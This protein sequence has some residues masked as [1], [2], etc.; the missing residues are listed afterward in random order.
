MRGTV[1]LKNYVE[2]FIGLKH[3]GIDPGPEVIKLFSCSTQLSM[4]F[5]LPLNVKMTTTVGILTFMSRKISILG[6]PVSEKKPI[7]FLYFYT[8]DHLKFRVQLS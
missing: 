8:Y 4:K 2:S 6:L 5:F 3:A 7:F 1:I